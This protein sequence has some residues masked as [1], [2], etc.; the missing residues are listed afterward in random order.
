MGEATC[1]G[2]QNLS[3]VSASVRHPADNRS[4]PIA[5]GGNGITPVAMSVRGMLRCYASGRTS[6]TSATLCIPFD[7]MPPS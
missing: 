7:A 6:T 5:G 2:G 4:Q 3:S 1:G